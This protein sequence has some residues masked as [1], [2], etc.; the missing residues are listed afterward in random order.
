M[1]LLGLLIFTFLVSNKYT[2]QSASGNN[3]LIE[4]QLSGWAM[5]QS[6]SSINGTCPEDYSPCTCQQLKFMEY[7]EVSCDGVSLH[8]V[9]SVLRRST[10]D[11]TMMRLTLPA[12]NSSIPSDTFGGKRV[13]YTVLA[14]SPS[15]T[16]L[17]IHPDAF[18]SSQDFTRAFE[19]KGCD[20]TRLDYTFLA[21][22]TV[23]RSLKFDNFSNSAGT[24]HTIPKVLPSLTDLS[25]V[26]SP[27]FHNFTFLDLPFLANLTSVEV[28]NCPNFTSFQG[29]PASM[30]GLRS[31]VITSCPQFKHW[32]V[33]SN[34]LTG[35]TDL[36]LSGS[37]L[38]D[39]AVSDL[40]DAIVAS[41]V[42]DTLTYL[43]LRDNGMT[44]IPEQ[45]SRLTNLKDLNLAHNSISL[46][47]NG[48]LNLV[49]SKVGTVYLFSNEL[50]AIEP[51]ALKGKEII[52]SLTIKIVFLCTI[53]FFLLRVFKTTKISRRHG[54]GENRLA[55]QQFD[56]FRG[57]RL[58]SAPGKHGQDGNGS[59]IRKDF[60]L[61]KYGSFL[62]IH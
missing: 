35:L 34:Q 57:F 22:F 55:E 46:L 59:W 16:P 27:D 17:Q 21:E 52:A 1:K 48:S 36:S 5:G 26:D 58:P 47:D 62:S 12:V 33:F 53:R 20:M 14:C 7:M 25:V 56:S 38:G 39:Q 44:K 31:L 45:I 13:L 29:L 23:L 42:A 2:I 18:R 19:I 32:N 28:N 43:N 9:Q 24:F 50:R 11:I 6:S 30:P 61:P 60:P 37:K 3:L 51:V 15:S 10:R 41:P 4:L 40:L 8:S 49:A 54:W